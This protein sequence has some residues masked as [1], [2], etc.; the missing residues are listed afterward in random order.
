MERKLDVD[1]LF[2]GLV[3]QLLP[4]LVV[5]NQTTDPWRLWNTADFENMQRLIA[6]SEVVQFPESKQ[7][8]FRETAVNYPGI[9][10]ST[11]RSVVEAQVVSNNLTRNITRDETRER[12]RS[13]IV[14]TPILWIASWV[15]S[16]DPEWRVKFTESATTLGYVPTIFSEQFKRVRHTTS[17]AY[18]INTELDIAN[19]QIL[20]ERY[21]DLVNTFWDPNFLRTDGGLRLFI[22]FLAYIYNAEGNYVP[23]TKVD[24]QTLPS[25]ESGQFLTFGA[26]TTNYNND[27]LNTFAYVISHSLNYVHAPHAADAIYGHVRYTSGINNTPY[28]A[29]QA[30]ASVVVLA[31]T[32]SMAATYIVGRVTGKQLNDRRNGFSKPVDNPPQ[33]ETPAPV[34]PVDNT[35]PRRARRGQ[36]QKR[37]RR[38]DQIKEIFNQFLNFLLDYGIRTNNRKQKYR[39]SIASVTV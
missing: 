27:Y 36:D 12:D 32:Y 4:Q 6:L 29:H 37:P 3:M 15:Y 24:Q 26:Y 13:I 28:L 21:P 10:T 1:I 14:F 39:S 20:V 8:I 33:Q 11:Q 9:G 2:G 34:T 22:G 19:W 23:F 7:N 35:G 5:I 18:R 25:F 16:F 17:S 31:G 38:N 30:S